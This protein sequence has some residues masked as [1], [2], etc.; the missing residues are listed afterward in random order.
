M[1]HPQGWVRDGNVCRWAR[2]IHGFVATFART[3]GVSE[4][5]DHVLANVATAVCQPIPGDKV[6]KVELT[7]TTGSR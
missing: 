4:G 5:Y 7:L 2:I 3:W 6:G 1:H